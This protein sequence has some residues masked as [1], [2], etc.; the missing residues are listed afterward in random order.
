MY[1]DSRTKPDVGGLRT[2]DGTGTARWHLIGGGSRGLRTRSRRK[3]RE[4]GSGSTAMAREGAGLKYLG[5]GE[6]KKRKDSRQLAGN[7]SW[8]LVYFS[9]AVVAVVAMRAAI[10]T[11]L[12]LESQERCPGG[13][14]HWTIPTPALPEEGSIG[15]MRLPSKMGSIFQANAPSGCLGK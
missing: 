7:G 8:L 9:W 10:R 14:G 13:G 2:S 15:W 3:R 1:P 11:L 6:V 4:S 12:K 5:S